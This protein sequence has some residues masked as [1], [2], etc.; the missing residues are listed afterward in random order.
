MNTKR[1][2]ML[3]RLNLAGLREDLARFDYCD[4]VEIQTDLIET[5]RLCLD[6]INKKQDQGV[7]TIK[8]KD[9]VNRQ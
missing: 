6:E 8:H 3:N 2:L 4:A 9:V 1:L 5:L 7:M